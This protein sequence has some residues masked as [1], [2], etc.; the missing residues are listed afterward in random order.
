MGWF[1]SF[2]RNYVEGEKDCHIL[3][4]PGLVERLN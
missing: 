1:F 3:C 4:P 2:L